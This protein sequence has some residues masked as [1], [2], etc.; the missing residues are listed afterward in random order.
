MKSIPVSYLVFSSAF[1]VIANNAMVSGLVM[2][3]VPFPG[4]IWKCWQNWN[5]SATFIVLLA[6]SI[7]SNVTTGPWIWN[8]GFAQFANRSNAWTRGPRHFAF[9]SLRVCCR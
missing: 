4:M 3:Y 7:L 2:R 1:T 6:L 8:R 9:G 5:V